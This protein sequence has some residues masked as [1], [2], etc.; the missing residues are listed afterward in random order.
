MR[1]PLTF[2]IALL[3]SSV[4][5][6]TVNWIEF[7]P[8]PQTSGG[9]TYKTSTPVLY[10]KLGAWSNPLPYSVSQ[11][12]SWTIAIPR[13]TWEPSSPIFSPPN[14]NSDFNPL[15]P[16]HLEQWTIEMS[17]LTLQQEST[18]NGKVILTRYDAAQAFLSGAPV[19]I[20]MYTQRKAIWHAHDGVS[21][22]WLELVP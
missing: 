12:V 2:L 14:W 3:S 9:N 5:A 1:G 17:P 22:P 19:T 18:Y 8:Y 15:V 13:H 21:A 11:S 16:N 7:G 20:F 4:L 6:Q 10:T